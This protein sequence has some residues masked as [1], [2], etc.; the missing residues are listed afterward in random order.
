[1]LPVPGEYGGFPSVH[2]IDEE[3]EKGRDFCKFSL[4]GRL[5][6]YKMTLEQVRSKVAS[7]W[8]PKGTWSITPLGK[9]FMMFRFE[10]FEDYQKVWNQ[11][12]WKNAE[13]ANMSKNQKKRWRKKNNTG[14]QSATIQAE[15]VVIITDD[16]TADKDTTL[17]V[18]N[19]SMATEINEENTEQ[20]VEKNASD[21]EVLTTT[22]VL[23]NIGENVVVAT[24]SVEKVQGNSVECTLP[25][26]PIEVSIETSNAFAELDIEED[27]VPATQPLLKE[28]GA[29]TEIWE[30]VILWI[31]FCD[32]LV[33][34]IT[35]LAPN[36]ARRNIKPIEHASV[37]IP[38]SSGRPDLRP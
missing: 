10:D 33:I 2:L 6:L 8:A 27:T 23:T 28:I 14:Q 24:D 30:G 32:A 31:M 16:P 34:M 15:N 5:D 29:V 19:P 17:E 13:V 20:L 12:S 35:S 4:V 1:M 26:I 36:A 7:L 37:T 11:G 22:E 3:V 25:P 38:R 21:N 9:G 18:E